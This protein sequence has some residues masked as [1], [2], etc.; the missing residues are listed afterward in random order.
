M[1]IVSELANLFI[2]IIFNCFSYKSN[3]V[4]TTH[5]YYIFVCVVR[6]VFHAKD[7][8]CGTSFLQCGYVLS[9][10]SVIERKQFKVFLDIPR[11]FDF[12]SVSE[13]RVF[14]RFI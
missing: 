1:V 2:P 10:C 6:Q 8:L 7:V 13:N 3:C 11:S 5:Q 14:M 4:S 12:T 9:R